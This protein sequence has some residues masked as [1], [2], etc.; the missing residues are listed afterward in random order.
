MLVCACA[1]AGAFFTPAA[2]A[3]VS[4]PL[5]PLLHADI[6]AQNLVGALTA[7]GTATGINLDWPGHADTVRS[8]GA[9]SGLSPSAAL[10]QLLDG[11]GFTFEFV[12]SRYVKIIETPT[13]RSNSTQ[14]A[15]P[16]AP[17]IE[18]VVV[19]G[20]RGEERVTRV[21]SDVVAWPD[22]TM[23]ASGVKDL[24]DIGAL[25]PGLEFDY[26]SSAGSGEYTNISIRG[27]TDRH[28]PTTGIYFDDAPLPAARSNTFG[29]VLPPYFDLE[30]IEILSGPQGAL[31]GADTQGGAVRFVPNQPSLTRF[32][33][34]AHA[35]WATTARGDPSY[36][37]A[38]AA[39]GP[40]IEDILGY[41]FSVWYRSD[42]GYVSRVDPFSGS[43]IDPHSN[44]VKRQSVRGALAYAPDAS[45]RVAPSVLYVSS[46]TRDSS[47]FFTYLSD[48]SGGA[49]NNGSLFPQPFDDTFYLASLRLTAALRPGKLDSLTSYHHR[50]G[51]LVIDDTESELWGGW[52]NPLGPA[53]PV[54]YADAVTTHGQLEES[55]FSQKVTLASR[56]PESG[57]HLSWLAGAFYSRTRVGEAYRTVAQSIPVLLGNPLDSSTSTTTVQTQVAGFGQLVAKS[58]RVTVIAGLRVEHEGLEVNN[59]GSNVG[60]LPFHARSGQTLTIPAFTASYASEDEHRLFYIAASEGYAPAG[61]AAAGVDAAVPSCFEPPA[62]Y[63]TDT[64]WSYELG[65]KLGLGRL[66][67]DT[68]VFQARWN[69]GPTATGTCSVIHLPGPAFSKGFALQAQA[70]LGD[71]VNVD[72]AL[73]YIDAHYTD[74]IKAGHS[75]IVNEGDALGTPPQ[76]AAP[77]SVRASI[78]RRLV[79]GAG[80]GVQATLRAEDIYRSHNPGPFYTGIPGSPY[81]QPTVG[82][83][84]ATNVLNLRVTFDRQAV[85]DRVYICTCAPH[86]RASVEVSIFLNNALDSQPTLLK[87]TKG[88]DRTLQ[89]FGSSSLF[90]GTTFRPR[91]VGVAGTWSF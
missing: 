8:A 18:Q 32:S 37:A 9:R 82:S 27:I 90:Y 39:G 26:F 86:D 58:G 35:E 61:F 20:T 7:F 24:A 52:D 47:S 51:S 91:T 33:S 76:V 81:Y 45:L 53:Y 16:G 41:R 84:P 59:L 66:H 71:Y 23:Q 1:L 77:W 68:T 10:S 54:S 79:L 34:T 43:T 21:A 42:G 89:S 22:T 87:Q 13:R 31:L 65:A 62:I 48:P 28:G 50:S 63:P 12:T 60:N 49:L 85:D 2:H 4:P 55:I 40:M 11:T 69:N 6:P 64:V 36:E 70:A 30:R 78:D 5:T 56:D 19:T 57:N 15:D 44:D 14:D 88:I 3:A 72:L 73:S 75:V 67:L 80:G 46:K 38:A 25:M 83:D 29:G 74:T 17:P